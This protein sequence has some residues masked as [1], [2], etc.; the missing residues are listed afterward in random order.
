MAC[1]GS[2]NHQAYIPVKVDEDTYEV[3]FQDS[4]DEEDFLPLKGGANFEIVRT[5]PALLS[6]RCLCYKCYVYNLPDCQTEDCCKSTCCCIKNGFGCENWKDPTLCQLFCCGCSQSGPV[7]ESSFPAFVR[8][9]CLFY[10]C[11]LH[12]PC[13]ATPTNFVK[14]DDWCTSQFCCIHEDCGMKDNCS[15]QFFCAK[16]NL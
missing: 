5:F 2:M 14:T 16:C 1:Y 13:I 12:E 8:C 6:L 3:P 11:G 9:Q 10:K 7:F 4:M 15:I